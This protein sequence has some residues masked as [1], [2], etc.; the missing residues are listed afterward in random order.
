MGSIGYKDESS[1]TAT[2]DG[3]FFVGILIGSEE[4]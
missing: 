4:V 1:I 3:G 2:L